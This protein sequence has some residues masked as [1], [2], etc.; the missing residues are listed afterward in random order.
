MSSIQKVQA[1][2]LI[3]SSTRKL[4]ENKLHDLA[5]I[6]NATVHNLLW[7]CLPWEEG[8]EWGSIR[9]EKIQFVRVVNIE[10]KMPPTR[11]YSFQVP[12]GAS[13]NPNPVGSGT[14]RCGNDERFL[15]GVPV[16]DCPTTSSRL[17][18]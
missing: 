8:S 7:F 18:Q 17:L 5:K 9:I 3:N 4:I 2:D 16:T 14:S 15:A 10:E 6:T 13:I 12:P 1:I 11:Q